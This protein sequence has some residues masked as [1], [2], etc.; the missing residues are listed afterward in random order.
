MNPDAAAQANPHHALPLRVARHKHAA[1]IAAPHA[2]ER[3]A[4]KLVR[5]HA[6]IKAESIAVASPA[7]G[8]EYH[9]RRLRRGRLHGRAAA[10]HRHQ[11]RG[12][13]RRPCRR[14]AFRRPAAWP[15]APA[16]SPPAAPSRPPLHAEWARRGAP[17]E[18]S[19]R[20]SKPPRAA[21][22][23][24]RARAFALGFHGHLHWH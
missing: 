11:R 3:H 23:V 16:E 9:P 1:R 10:R 4:H 20:G 7:C 5:P 2:T 15:V 13:G 21:V 6:R 12:L 22:C 17:S 18:R 24:C 8:V 14:L 19:P